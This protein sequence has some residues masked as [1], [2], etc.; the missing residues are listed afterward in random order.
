MV[1]LQLNTL[2]SEIEG[3]YGKAKFCPE[4]NSTCLSLEPGMYFIMPY[5]LSF[6]YKRKIGDF[7]CIVV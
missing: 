6:V 1:G 3:I 5:L 7:C 2:Q 4:G